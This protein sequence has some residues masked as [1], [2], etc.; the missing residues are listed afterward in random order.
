MIFIHPYCF[1]KTKNKF[2]KRTNTDLTPN[3]E[4]HQHNFSRSWNLLEGGQAAAATEGETERSLLPADRRYRDND[5]SDTFFHPCNDR[6]THVGTDTDSGLVGVCRG[7]R[8]RAEGNSGQKCELKTGN[9][10]QQCQSREQSVRRLILKHCCCWVS[11]SQT[12]P[13]AGCRGQQQARPD[14]WIRNPV[15]LQWIL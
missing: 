1:Q 6:T 9:T 2:F 15:G 10:E 11:E 13:S 4:G 5:I 12:V 3:W 14:C 8:G 7:G